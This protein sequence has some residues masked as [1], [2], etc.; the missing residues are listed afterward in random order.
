MHRI[1]NGSSLWLERHSVMRY[2]RCVWN[3][4]EDGIVSVKGPKKGSFDQRNDIDC[5]VRTPDDC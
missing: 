1:M 3:R 4:D 5:A 2:Q